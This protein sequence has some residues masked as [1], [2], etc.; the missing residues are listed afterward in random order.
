[1]FHINN[2]KLILPS[3]YSTNIYSLHITPSYRKDGRPKKLYT[4]VAY[5]MKLILVFCIYASE[6]QF[7]K[8]VS[9]VYIHNSMEKN[10]NS[11]Y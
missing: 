10:I 11:L 3:T 7:R 5:S 8:D 1:M 4:Y 2:V 9:D 6:K